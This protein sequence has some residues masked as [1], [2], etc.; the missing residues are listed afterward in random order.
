MW[1]HPPTVIAHLFMQEEAANSL[2]STY[3]FVEGFCTEVVLALLKLAQQHFAT[4][5]TPLYLFSPLLFLLLRPY[6]SQGL[7]R[8][9]FSQLTV[10]RGAI[11]V[12]ANGRFLCCSQLSSQ[13]W[14]PVSLSNLWVSVWMRS[15][16]TSA[17][18]MHICAVSCS[19]CGISE[20]FW[21]GQHVY[22][23]ATLIS[24]SLV[25]N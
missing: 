19:L 9:V 23:L 20:C 12:E 17:C 22:L 8:P 21:N 16:A 11:I 25:W 10:S 24:S 4:S 6:C 3:I 2:L 5:W 7:S 1:L 15:W 18:R 13:L 14:L